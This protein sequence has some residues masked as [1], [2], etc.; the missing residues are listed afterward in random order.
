MA[1][2]FGINVQA[3]NLKQCMRHA[4]PRKRPRWSHIPIV[5]VAMLPDDPEDGVQILGLAGSHK[6]LIE[7]HSFLDEFPKS[8]LISSAS[9]IKT[10]YFSAL[11]SLCPTPH[12][13]IAFMNMKTDSL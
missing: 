7:F 2:Y 13:R 4:S 8:R 11:D 3:F 10:K 5:K 12:A 1:M 9:P 6:L